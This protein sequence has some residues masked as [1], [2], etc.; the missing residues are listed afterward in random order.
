MRER[1][2]EP[3]SDGGNPN[4]RVLV[5]GA[6]GVGGYFGGRLLE[7]ERDVT[8][9]VRP[10]RAA[11]LAQKGLVIRSRFGDFCRPA[12]PTV[13]ADTLNDPFDVIVLS[14][15]SYDLHSAI[16]DFAPAVGPNSVILP[17]LNGMRHLDVL[18]ERFGSARV[19]G[20]QCFVSAAL[21]GSGAVIHFNDAHT[22]TF[23]ERDGSVSE[24]VRA[25]ESLMGG[26][27]FHWQLSHAILLEMWEKWIFIATGAGMTCLMRAPFGDILAA[28]GGDLTTQLYAEC[29]AIASANGYPPRPEISRKNLARMNIPGSTLAASMFRDI[30]RNSPI[31]ADQI[32]GDLLNR[33]NERGLLSPLLRVAYIHLKAYEAR[34]EREIR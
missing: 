25:M 10:Q 24:R 30:E 33:G 7:A 3:E 17:L 9:L 20:G 5:V 29:A 19:I 13:T 16:D 23:G 22:L 26:V 2:I 11:T 27:K 4:L 6:G 18:D 32:V 8:F 31:E 12:P 15:K 28:R 1:A 34:R 14:S 21:D